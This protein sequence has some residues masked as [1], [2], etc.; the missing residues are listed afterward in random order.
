MEANDDLPFQELVASVP[1]DQEEVD[2]L[3][4][5]PGG[6]GEQ[7]AHFVDCLHSRFNSVEFLL[8]ERAMSAGTL[9]AL[10]GDKIWMRASSHIGPIDPQIL[11]K[12]GQFV[13]AQSIL[14]LLNMIQEVGNEALSKG[15]SV[16]WHLVRLLDTMDQLLVGSAIDLSQYSIRLATK[17]LNDYKFRNWKTHSTTGVPVTKEERKRRAT[18]IAAALCDNQRWNSH[19]HGIT[20]KVAEDELRIKINHTETNEALEKALR[21]FWALLYW[22]FENSEM[23]KV[24]LSQKFLLVRNKPTSS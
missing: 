8:P 17:F 14:S 6:S 3:I 1:Q 22:T 24:F 7:I 15:Q 9:W 4:V 23:V 12:E 19:G 13:S 5:T 16:P 20:R 21:R 11:S 2:V 10:S 18:E